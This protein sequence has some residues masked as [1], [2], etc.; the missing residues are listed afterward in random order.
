M[1]TLLIGTC[2]GPPACSDVHT[3]LFVDGLDLVTRSDG[4]ALGLHPRQLL[5][6]GGPLHPT[7][8]PREVRI[9]DLGGP[10]S[11][12]GGLTITV[13]LRG[14]T[15]VWSGLMYP[16]REHGVVEEVRFQLAQ[17]LGEVQRVYGTWR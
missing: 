12:R 3:Y 14:E 9:A 7:D 11:D 15:V 1:S 4:G 13:R 17:Y 2:P 8:A 10:G 6:P 5:R 16:D